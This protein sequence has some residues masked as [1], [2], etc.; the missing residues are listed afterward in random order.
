MDMYGIVWL[1]MLAAQVNDTQWYYRFVGASSDYTDCSAAARSERYIAAGCR[2][3]V[4][5]GTSDAMRLVL[6]CGHDEDIANQVGWLEQDRFIA[7]TS[8][9]LFLLDFDRG[10]R[11]LDIPGAPSA[12][13]ADGSGRAI[14]AT[15]QGL[16][17]IHPRLGVKELLMTDLEESPPGRLELRDDF[18]LITGEHRWLL[19]LDTT[20]RRRL[21]DFGAMALLG[22]GRILA[23]DPQGN[24][25]LYG[26]SGKLTD[27]F[28]LGLDPFERVTRVT[29]FRDH[30][31]IMTSG[32]WYLS[33]PQRIVQSGVLPFTI[34]RFEPVRGFSDGDLP[35]LLAGGQ[36]MKPYRGVDTADQVCRR[37]DLGRL[38]QA[39][40]VVQH[41]TEP[42]RPDCTSA[43]WLPRVELSYAGSKDTTQR[44]ADGMLRDI[45]FDHHG[46]IGIRL[47]WNPELALSCPAMQTYGLLRQEIMRQR[48][49]I[50]EM[51]TGLVQAYQ[52]SC[53][54]RDE[55][56]A[57]EIQAHIRLLT[58]GVDK[59]P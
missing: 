55:S 14:V 44:F 52:T 11:R 26:A 42:N 41:L 18:V 33:S 57:E 15:S 59:Y 7:A 39:A 24:A 45:R 25:R 51:L 22:K 47:S 9:G 28:Q 43:G 27:T 32:K 35:W 29:G 36:V 4:W 58:G 46:V 30:A 48:Q 16:W 8:C 17:L 3:G 10:V 34:D 31:L 21:S 12:L 37:L 2:Q 1:V 19:T 53:R 56:A 54:Q 20:T 49:Q 6:P 50:Y 23:V 5:F 38:F 13:D 40:V